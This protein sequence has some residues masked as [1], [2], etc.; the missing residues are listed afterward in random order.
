M[1]KEDKFPRAF[2]DHP[3]FLKVALK[4]LTNYDEAE[5]FSKIYPN[6]VERFNHLNLF[7]SA[8][9]EILHNEA[10]TNVKGG[11]VSREDIYEKL[12][13]IINYGYREGGIYWFKEEVTTAYALVLIEK[14]IKNKLNYKS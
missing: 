5:S 10:G 3:S 1:I 13:Q 9:F 6:E 12:N 8:F 2:L 14:N 4:E 7:I 11:H